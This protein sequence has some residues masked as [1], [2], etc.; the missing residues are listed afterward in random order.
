M[1]Q[2]TSSEVTVKTINLKLK[3]STGEDKINIKIDTSV[4]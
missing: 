3:R 2:H 4:S 1:L